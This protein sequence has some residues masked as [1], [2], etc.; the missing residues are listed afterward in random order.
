ML[1]EH[2]FSART[3]HHYQ[4]IYLFINFF[5]YYFIFIQYHVFFPI[6]LDSEQESVLQAYVD[7]VN[8]F[9]EV[10]HNY[11]VTDIVQQQFIR[12]HIN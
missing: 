9:F 1:L 2:D 5:L 8:K 6:V 10:G 3:C 11:F 12:L 4:V 7:P